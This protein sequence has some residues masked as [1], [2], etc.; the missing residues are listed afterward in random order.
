M[1]LAVRGDVKQYHEPKLFYTAKVGS[2]IKD[3]LGMEPKRFALKVESWVVGDFGE[4]QAY[5]NHNLLNNFH[6]DSAGT[7]SQRLSLTKL[8]SLCRQHIQDGL[9]RL[10]ENSLQ[11]HFLTLVIQILLFLL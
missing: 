11:A 7:V 10:S 8:V 2:F 9:G 5:N 6:V 4:Q 1:Y 3:V